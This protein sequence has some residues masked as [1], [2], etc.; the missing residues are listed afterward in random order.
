MTL[1]LKAAVSN[2][3]VFIAVLT[4][5]TAIKKSWIV[6]NTHNRR[7]MLRS[8]AEDYGSKKYKDSK[9]SNTL[10]PSGRKL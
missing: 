8:A 5:F 1:P 4:S 7:Q 9:H 6:L 10:A 2:E 3:Y